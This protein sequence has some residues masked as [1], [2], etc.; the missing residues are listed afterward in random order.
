MARLMAKW[1]DRM[2][3]WGFLAI[4]IVIALLVFLLSRLGCGQMPVGKIEPVMER[5]SIVTYTTQTPYELTIRM[6]DRN[7]ISEGEIVHDPSYISG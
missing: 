3:N 2:I 7:P 4:P 5:S 6:E 1:L